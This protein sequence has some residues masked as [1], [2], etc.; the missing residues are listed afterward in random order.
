M[1]VPLVAAT[2]RASA[3][4]DLRLIDAVKNSDARVTQSLLKQHLDVNASEPDGT[5]ALHWAASRGDLPSVKLLLAA[6]ASPNVA[7]R[8]GMT[9]LLLACATGT[10]AIVDALLDAGVDVNSASPEGQTALMTAARS[11]SVDSIKSLI[12]HGAKVNATESWHRQTAI[13]WAASENHPD[14]I[15]ALAEAGADVNARSN[16]GFTP[17]LFAARSG[18]LEAVRTLLDLGAHASDTLQPAAAVKPATTLSTAQGGGLPLPTVGGAGTSG[19]V[20]AITNAHY[21]VAKYLVEHGA[22]PNA[23]DQG[24]TALHQLSYTRRP[25]HGKGLPPPEPTG[26]VDSLELAKALLAHGANP[27]ARQTKE[28]IDGNRF[29][30][31]R[32][33]ATPLLL[34]AKHADVPLMRVLAANG[35][36]VHIVNGDHTTVL[37]V[38]AGVGLFNLGE[39]A[40]TN[41]EAF[42]AVKLA[43]ELGDHNVNAANDNGWTPLHGAAIRGADEVV[44]FLSDRGGDFEARIHGGYCRAG[45]NCF[46]E[47]ANQERPG[48]T[49]LRIA[50]G[51]MYAGT[52]KRA[53]HTAALIRRLM[54]EKGLKVPERDPN[55][56]AEGGLQVK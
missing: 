21:E 38:A 4:N 49:P 19:L 3:D 44:Q 13:M 33:G 55:D 43:W 26:E 32:V 47:A 52:V 15:R 31:N 54:K 10:A 12:G 42:E 51:V 46:P 56:V 16:G 2:T 27:N 40:G 28:I 9:P 37:A 23:A 5:T 14:A 6:G 36:D 17:L 18:K 50:D 45:G 8:Y 22:D 11:G 39:S 24:W 41:E 30:L 25:N 53:D 20:L 35:A 34:A 29:N 48:W 1:F 7:N